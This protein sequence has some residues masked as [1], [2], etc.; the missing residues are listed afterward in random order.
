MSSSRDPGKNLT[1]IDIGATIP[2]PETILGFKGDLLS[3]RLRPHS[4][5]ILLSFGCYT[6]SPTNTTSRNHHYQTSLQYTDKHNTRKRDTSRPHSNQLQ[7]GWPCRQAQSRLPSKAATLEK[8]HRHKRGNII[9]T[10]R[11]ASPT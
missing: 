4:L 6:I 3:Y 2:R 5:S 9:V 1:D 11:K 8:S 7:N 10:K